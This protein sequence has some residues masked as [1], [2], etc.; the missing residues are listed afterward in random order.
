VSRLRGWG[1]RLV[2]WRGEPQRGLVE[3]SSSR[4]VLGRGQSL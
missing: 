3:R 4:G 1:E 2:S